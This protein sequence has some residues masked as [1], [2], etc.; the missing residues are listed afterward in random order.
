MGGAF[1]LPTQV[2]QLLINVCKFVSMAGLLRHPLE[3]III[4]IIQ[5]SGRNLFN[6]KTQKS[7]YYGVDANSVLHLH[8]FDL[9]E[10]NRVTIWQIIGVSINDY[11]TAC[12]CHYQASI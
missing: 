6:V 9:M 4:I 3:Y 11:E 7:K 8:F 5:F 10:K 2:K 1:H 12:T